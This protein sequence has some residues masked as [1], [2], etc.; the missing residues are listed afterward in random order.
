M[1]NIE[2]IEF[3]VYLEGVEI[4]AR[5]SGAAVSITPNA[6]V[7]FQVLFPPV[8]FEVVKKIKERTHVAVFFRV[9]SHET[10][11]PRDWQLLGEGEYVG[12]GFS[13]GAGGSMGTALRFVGL[14]NYWQTIYA[15]HFQ[16]MKGAASTA[17]CEAELVF[18]TGA[19]IVTASLG[20]GINPIPLQ[21]EL[22]S[23]LGIKS[24]T[25]P[26]FFVDLLKAMEKK[27]AFFGAAAKRL[28][29]NE[30]IMAAKDD[31]I[32]KLV[33]LNQLLNL[34]D[35]VF[36]QRPQ[37]AKLLDILSAL[38]S[39]VHYGYQVLPFPG[40]IGKQLRTLW[41]KPD[42]PFVAPPRCNVIFPGSME[43]FEF[44]RDYLSEPTRLRLSLPVVANDGGDSLLRQHF[45]A[46]QQ[47]QQVADKVK[48][49]P[50]G[51]RNIEAIQISDPATRR[52]SREDVKGV[53]PQVAT[54]P[55]F[56]ALTLGTTDVNVRNKYYSGLAE[57]ELLLAQH[58][59][60]TM[61]ISGR[62]MPNLVCGLPAVVIMQHGVVLGTIESLSHQ[63]YPDGH[64]STLIGLSTCREEDLSGVQN[65]IW[66]NTRFTDISKVD[67]TYEELLGVKSVM[68]PSADE[69]S[70][71]GVHFKDQMTAAK[72]IRQAY[73]VA[74][75]ADAFEKRFTKRPI[76]TEEETFRFLGAAKSGRDYVGAPFR[77]EWV[78]QAREFAQALQN[79]I[80]DAT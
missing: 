44:N 11:N 1:A 35:G 13:K 18:G 16:S 66:K 27:N 79:Q 36:S 43:S 62:F 24:T 22:R 46:P 10:E 45:Y 58:A 40:Y 54:L 29:L 70:I 56:D 14:E 65:P 28:K 38:M 34:I 60:R 17:F 55:S 8:E 73:S 78:T 71:L 26:E 59:P 61:R 72:A 74:F 49:M 6:P 15:M 42:L 57:Y 20:E 31:D 21:Q 51:E 5:P 67:A 47:M 77:A 80:Q 9:G 2:N 53:I 32:Q 12:Y 52:E 76:A 4:P 30:R 37:D 39:P 64:P 63:I 25:V 68:A 48:L 33:Q 3:K 50:Q 41:L 7:Q 69:G 75:D 19:T 23:Q